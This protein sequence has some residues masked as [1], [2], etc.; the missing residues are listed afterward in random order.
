[1]STKKR[2]MAA[3]ATF[4][5]I[6]AIVVLVSGATFGFFSDQTGPQAATF[7][8][9]SVSLDHSAVFHCQVQGI[10]AGDTNYVACRYDVTYTGS[11]PAYI[12][13]QLTG[14]D[15]DLYNLDGMQFQVG[16]S[17]AATGYWL[18]QPAN[19]SP[20]LY[21]GTATA[22]QVITLY[23][24]FMLPGSAT[25]QGAS[26]TVS[27]SVF[28]VQQANNPIGPGCSIGNPCSGISAY[29]SIPA[30][31]PGNLPSE[32]PEA[33][34]FSL[35][36]NEVTFAPNGQ[37]QLTDVTVA[38]S[39]W[40][41][42]QGHWFDDTC[43]TSPGA[44]FQQE[45]VLAIYNPPTGNSNTPSGLKAVADQTFD[46][47]FR[48]SA[49]NVHCTG[50]DS[51]KWYQASTGKCFNG[52]ATTV[53]FH[54]SNPITVPDTIVYGITYDTANHGG[55]PTHVTSP[56]DSLNIALSQDPTDVTVGHDTNP[57]TL[58]QNTNQVQGPASNGNTNSVGYCSSTGGLN[59]FR[60]DSPG[61]SCWGVAHQGG[62]YSTPSTAP[63]YV[64][65]V[66]F[67]MQGG[68][69]Q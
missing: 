37:R 54:F 51:G 3:A 35:F 31:L 26:A 60:L 55:N 48:P 17:N 20:I 50:A 44:T 42:E 15:G 49:D 23:V 28:A 27:L 6:A 38:L 41:C 8:S 22:S 30:T 62:S 65:A 33:Y 45:M 4:T 40:S 29:D 13:A 36:G 11:L 25:H 9:G 53:T 59:V 18:D 52:L 39:D 12:G 32:G 47:P 58:W 2:F 7:T 68:G 63:Y 67:R 16:Q 64:P 69:W 10:A 56:A 1:M 46:I 21:E 24:G 66:Q 43:A 57:G 14:A 61:S 5:S 34:S 19:Q